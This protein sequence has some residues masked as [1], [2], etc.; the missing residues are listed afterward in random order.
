LQLLH[1]FALTIV[2][3]A[4]SQSQTYLVLDELLVV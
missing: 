2:F 1:W 3:N 4:V